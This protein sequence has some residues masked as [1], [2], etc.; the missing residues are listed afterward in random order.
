MC[1]GEVGCVQ[2]RSGVCAGEEWGVCR[3]GVGCVQGR[4]V[5]VRSGVCACEECV[6]VHVWM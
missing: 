1:R 5:H 3:G 2:G 6:V 4:S